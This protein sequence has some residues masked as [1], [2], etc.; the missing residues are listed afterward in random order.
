[1]RGWNLGELAILLGVVVL[2]VAAL[3]TAIYPL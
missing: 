3:L 2:M 1:M